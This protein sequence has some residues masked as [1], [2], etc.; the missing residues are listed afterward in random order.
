MEKIRQFEKIQSN[1]DYREYLQ[2]NATEIMKYNNIECYYSKALNPSSRESE[3]KNPIQTQPIYGYCNN[4]DLKN[5]YLSREQLNSKMNNQSF[6]LQ[7]K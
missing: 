6:L 1:W 2:K 3:K 7:H 4:S 5:L